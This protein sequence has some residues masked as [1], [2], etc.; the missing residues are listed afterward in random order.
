MLEYINDPDR[1]LEALYCQDMAMQAKIFRINTSGADTTEL[2]LLRIEIRN[3]ISDVL[4][5]TL[6]KFKCLDEQIPISI[7]HDEVQHQ[8]ASS[9]FNNRSFENLVQTWRDMSAH[10]SYD[11]RNDVH[12]VDIAR[13]A[14]YDIPL[15][16]GT[17]A[18]AHSQVLRALNLSGNH[19]RA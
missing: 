2:W 9:V 16:H 8:L 7:P 1:L 11:I 5:T 13:W 14:K 4:C 12:G 3:I 15:K 18:Q 10:T 6:K 19:F 17:A